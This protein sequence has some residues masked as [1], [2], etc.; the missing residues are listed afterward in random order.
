MTI[1][2]IG[3]AGMI[4]RKIAASLA[5]EPLVLADVVPADPLPGAEVLTLDLTAP[6]AP[7]RL[8]ASRPATIY[9][10]AAIVS[11]EAEAD[12]DKGYAV[13]LDTTRAL[14]EE[15]RR[16][17]NYHPRLVYASS[18]AVF[19]RPFP[20]AI[21]DDFHTVPLTSY[22]TQKAISELLLNDYSR[23]GIID[24][25]ALRLPT[26]CIRPGLPNRAASSF[27]SNIL[28]EPLAGKTANLPVPE[29]TRHWFASPRAAVGF[30]RHAAT[31][32]TGPLQAD[33]AITVPGLTGT[34][35]DQLAALQR[36]AGPAALKLITLNPDPAVEKIVGGWAL[37][38]TA[39]R[40]L[41][42]GFQADN[43]FDD[44]IAAHLAENP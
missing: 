2:I 22:G 5:N 25:V 1:L 30:F 38:F 26:I 41:N 19:G 34:V 35:A 3:A 23:R 10:L 14:L 17:D 11:G 43:S 36:A 15:I 6:D 9:H 37:E 16:M 20:D 44:I 29:S 31:M 33:R 42:L 7:Q 21:P 18:A 12:F 39:T 24:G 27:F 32:D 28:R 40:A 4:G 8:L 13:N